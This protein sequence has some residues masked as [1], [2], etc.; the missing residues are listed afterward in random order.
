MDEGMTPARPRRGSS[1]APP[2][3]GACEPAAVKAPRILRRAIARLDE[4]LRRRD[5][6]IEYSTSAACIY[7]L[8]VIT[9]AE[10]YRLSDGSS[11]AIGDACINLHLWNEH[12]PVFPNAGPT[13]GWA[14]AMSGALA[15]SLQELCR[16]LSEHREYDNVVAIVATMGFGDAAQA[17]QIARIAARY[18]FEQM[19]AAGPPSARER[20]HQFGENILISLLVL[21]QNPLALRANTLRRAR[22]RVVMS[23]SRLEQRYGNAAQRHG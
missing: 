4:S 14:R 22:T 17:D 5:H 9:S 21:A 15:V 6:V 3:L 1:L 2:P 8:Q 11:I 23:R 20:L 19:P 13:L 10:P 18:G 16:F 12:L 7:R